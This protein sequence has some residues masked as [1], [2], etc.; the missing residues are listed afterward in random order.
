M[1][2]K[3]LLFIFILAVSFIPSEAFSKEK[4]VDKSGRK[5]KWVKEEKTNLFRVQVKSETLFTSKQKAKNQFEQTLKNIIVQRLGAK[6]DSLKKV[7]ISRFIDRYHWAEIKGL[8][9]AKIYGIHDTL[10]LDSYWEKYR[11]SKGGYLFKFHALYN[12]SSEEIEKI[13]NQF[14]QLD[15]RIT[16]RIEPIRT[17]M[18]GKNSISWLFEAKDTLFSILEVAPQNYHDN[19]LS[20]ITQIEE[21]LAIV[22][23]EIVRREKSF[24]KFQATMNGSLIP[25]RDKP[26]VSSTCAKI[27]NVSITENFCTIEF[28]SRYCLKQDPESGFK[29][30]LGAG[31]HALRRSILIF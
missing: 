6:S 31:N 29:I 3:S 14:E 30:D 13:A 23:I 28:D 24:I 15:T 17:K 1:L 8:S 7:R 27:T 12:C 11:L 9:F 5:P 16:F 4:V 2:Q 10:L 26:K 18:K 22:K 20:M 19:I 21:N 25:I